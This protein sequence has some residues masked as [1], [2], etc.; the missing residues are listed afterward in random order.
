MPP[1]YKKKTGK[2]FQST[3]I[4]LLYEKNNE[5]KSRDVLLHLRNAKDFLKEICIIVYDPWLYK[6]LR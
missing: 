4:M 6:I 2:K 1:S 5:E 3:K